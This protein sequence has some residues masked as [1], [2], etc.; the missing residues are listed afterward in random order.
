VTIF[1]NVC[2]VTT[3]ATVWQTS[4]VKGLQALWDNTAAVAMVMLLREPYNVHV[5]LCNAIQLQPLNK[6]IPETVAH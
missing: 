6:T 1:M 2:I 4:V 5:I 3:V